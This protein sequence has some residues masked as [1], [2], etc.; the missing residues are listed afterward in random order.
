MRGLQ[1]RFDTALG[2]VADSDELALPDRLCQA[3]AEVL[4]MDGAAIS[5]YVGHDISLPVGASGPD[6]CQGEAIQF[7]VGEGPCLEAF[8]TRRPVLVPDLPDPASSAWS[9]WPTYTEQFVEQT[10]YRA[11]FTFPLL[12][13]GFPLASLGLYRRAGEAPAP[14]DDLQVLVGWIA[15]RLETAMLS[16]QNNEPLEQWIAGPT[17]QRR[18]LVWQAQAFVVQANHLTPAQATA[19][20]RAQAFTAGRSLDDIAADI[21]SG[22]LPVP[23]L[24]SPA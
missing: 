13:S 1:A 12:A 9:R 17:S 23:V 6:A 22:R 18:H 8:A 2:A 11:V 19:L 21:V 7:T 14:L 4:P 5:M 24:R 15:G 16:D 10:D 20:L 3:V